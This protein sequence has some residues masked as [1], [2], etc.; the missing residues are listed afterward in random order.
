MIELHKR[1][2]FTAPSGSISDTGIAQIQ[3]LIALQLMSAAEWAKL[4]P[5]TTYR[6]PS[7]P[8]DWDW[9][10]LLETGDYKGTFPKRVRNYYYKVHRLKCPDTFIQEIG[11]LARAHSSDGLTYTFDFTDQ[12]DWEAGDFADDSS[13]YWNDRAGAKQMIEDNGGWAVRFFEDVDGI[14]RAWVA[15]IHDDMYIVFNGY[16]FTT[17]QIARVLATWLNVS[18]KKIR[19]TNQGGTAYALYNEAHPQ[20]AA[21]YRSLNTQFRS[22]LRG[23]R[24]TLD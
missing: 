4:N 11:N 18:Y 21:G 2:T 13:C 23:I 17:L 5:T 15:P 12:I 1:Y 24:P 14:A 19:L 9:I 6:L 7:L 8:D 10:W 20:Q 3:R 16:G 22:K